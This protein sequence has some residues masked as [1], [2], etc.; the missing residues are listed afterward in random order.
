MRDE[1]TL[2]DIGRVGAFMLHAAPVVVKIREQAQVSVMILE[3]GFAWLGNRGDFVTFR[4]FH[5]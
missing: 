2:A 1:A 3:I 5:E 4:F